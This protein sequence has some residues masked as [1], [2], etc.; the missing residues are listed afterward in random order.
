MAAVEIF[1]TGVEFST[2]VDG[3]I[4]SIFCRLVWGCS[5]L[6]LL[7]ARLNDDGFMLAFI[8]LL[9]LLLLFEF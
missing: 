4:F 6:A 2:V 5:W 8:L 7:F 9:L 1:E 3:F